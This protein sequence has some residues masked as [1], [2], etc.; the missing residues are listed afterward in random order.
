M[1]VLFLTFAVVFLVLITV[2][3]FADD[4]SYSE[5]GGG[6]DSPMTPNSSIRMVRERVDIR[7]GQKGAVVRCVFVFK[8]EGSACSVQMGFPECQWAGAEGGLFG[9]LQQF[10]S[11][12]DSEKAEVKHRFPSGKHS[13]DNGQR[14]DYTSWYVKR[15]DFAQ[16]QTRTVE[17]DY[18]SMY[19]RLNTLGSLAE[20]TFRYVLETGATWRGAIGEIAVNVDATRLGNIRKIEL[21]SGCVKSGYHQWKWIAR[22]VKPKDNFRIT[23]RPHS[24]LLNGEDVSQRMDDPSWTWLEDPSGIVMIHSGFISAVGGKQVTD[25]R[26]RTC[27][28]RYGGHVLV[29]KD[30]TRDAL[31]DSKVVN[32]PISIDVPHR[33]YEG[34]AQESAVPL[35]A[36][37]KWFGGSVTT[38][39]KTGKLDVMLRNLNTDASRRSNHH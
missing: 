34:S 32:L 18:F 27:T 4:G 39:K 8:N 26:K 10:V 11:Y 16:G 22:N 9:G 30:G 21:P 20:E 36:I 19:G 2:F 5:A 33:Y 7:L 38:D 28:V 1:R 23:L 17:D 31:L 24:P 15:V 13:Y 3:A 37:I 35:V 29:M 6:S 14:Q 12:I 25:V